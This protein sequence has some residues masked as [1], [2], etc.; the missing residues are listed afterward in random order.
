MFRIVDKIGSFQ[1]KNKSLVL[2]IA[3]INVFVSIQIPAKDKLE[4]IK[5]PNAILRLV[6]DNGLSAHGAFQRADESLTS[7]FEF[8][9]DAIAINPKSSAFANEWM[10]ESPDFIRDAKLLGAAN[11]NA[12]EYIQ[13]EFQNGANISL[14]L[15]R[16]KYFSNE[17]VSLAKKL[18]KDHEHKYCINKLSSRYFVLRDPY[19]VFNNKL[20]RPEEEKKIFLKPS[21]SFDPMKA[22]Q[23]NVNNIK[24]FATY[25]ASR[26]LVDKRLRESISRTYR[27]I[28]E[29][30]DCAKKVIENRMNEIGEEF[31]QLNRENYNNKKD[32]DPFKVDPQNQGD[33]IFIK[34]S[35]IDSE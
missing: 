11:D 18:K 3:I 25:N 17:V 19:K 35:S 2:S 16:K 8:M 21:A 10:K 23:S 31:N 9:F 1:V 29:I 5:D 20:D 27:N 26:I 34:N 22:M 24:N 7:D 28:P 15:D 13:K 4:K 30:L 33:F 6:G 12:L 14:I 32:L